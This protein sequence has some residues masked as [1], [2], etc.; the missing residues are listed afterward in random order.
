[1]FLLSMGLLS[2]TVIAL[3]SLYQTLEYRL[4]ENLTKQRGVK[5]SNDK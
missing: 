4:S 2:L 5:F 1:M 3:F